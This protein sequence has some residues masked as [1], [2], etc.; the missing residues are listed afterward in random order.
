VSISPTF[1]EQILHQNPFAKKFQTQ[2]QTHK[3]CAKKL[4][5]ENAAHKILVKLTLGWQSL[6]WANAL[7]FHKTL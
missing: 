1:Y 6:P 4:S 5:Y 3:S 2:I 7:A